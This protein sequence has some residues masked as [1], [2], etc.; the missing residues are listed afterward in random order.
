MLK[1]KKVL[2]DSVLTVPAERSKKGGL[3]ETESADVIE[4]MIDS[5]LENPK[6][7]GTQRQF[8]ESLQEY[9]DTNGYLSP[10]QEEILRQIYERKL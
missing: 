8:V 4:R 9:Y 5:L 7:K 6:V 2:W 1:E 10:R 3:K